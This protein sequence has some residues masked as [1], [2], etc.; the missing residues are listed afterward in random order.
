M[1][2]KLTHVGTFLAISIGGAAAGITFL[3]LAGSALHRWLV[4]GPKLHAGTNWMVV[5]VGGTLAIRSLPQSQRLQQDFTEWVAATPGNWV[6]LYEVVLPANFAA[7]DFQHHIVW[8]DTPLGHAPTTFVQFDYATPTNSVYRFH[9]SLQGKHGDKWLRPRDQ[10]LRLLVQPIHLKTWP[11]PEV[12]VVAI[13]GV[14]HSGVL[15]ADDGQYLLS[16]ASDFKIPSVPPT[17]G[18]ER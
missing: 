16:T 5:P 10:P 15:V 14:E 11:R 3:L 2:T 7:L 13:E 6:R 9:W 8:G 18:T 4:S 17:P 1:N 12:S